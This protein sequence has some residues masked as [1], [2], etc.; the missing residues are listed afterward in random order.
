MSN[1]KPK[2]VAYEMN[3]KIVSM[4]DFEHHKKFWKRP[5]TTED[6]VL[7]IFT[8]LRK[9]DHPELEITHKSLE[10]WGGGSYQIRVEV[11]STADLEDLREKAMAA[12]SENWT[13]GEFLTG[14]LD[15]L[16]YASLTEL[17]AEVISVTNNSHIQNN[18]LE[19][20]FPP[21][22]VEPA[23]TKAPRVSRSY[24]DSPSP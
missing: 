24:D 2:V 17:V 16:E 10:H 1:A 4:A 18:G 7:E 5:G 13:E 9:D 20:T 14:L 19:I 23:H 21:R 15:G 3:V 11:L 12:V 8:D 6:R 22:E